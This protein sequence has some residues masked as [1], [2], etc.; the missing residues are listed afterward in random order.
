MRQN[1]VA[2]AVKIARNRW[3]R[4]ATDQKRLASDAF[5]CR[6]GENLAALVIQ[7]IRIS[8]RHLPPPL[9]RRQFCGRRLR[10]RRGC[11][12]A[13]PLRD[14]A[15]HRRRHH[16]SHESSFANYAACKRLS[17][18]WP[19]RSRQE[20][21]EPHGP[22]NTTSPV[23]NSRWRSSTASAAVESGTTCCLALFILSGGGVHNLRSKSTSAQRV[24]SASAQ[25]LGP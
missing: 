15:G 21:G 13:Q 10:R 17:Q 1:R 16:T 3:V 12:P 11:A 20:S 6:E 19:A 22:G 18:P 2:N 14:H 5:A 7:P 25:R 4:R 23:R 9:H 24:S 8:R